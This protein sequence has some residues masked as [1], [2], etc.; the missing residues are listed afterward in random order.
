[1]P[2]GC[3]FAFIYFL[4]LVFLYFAVGK[5]YFLPLSV[6]MH[7]LN[8]LKASLVVLLKGNTSG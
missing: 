7:V 2:A 6:F 8:F 5:K 1:M 3:A 4:A